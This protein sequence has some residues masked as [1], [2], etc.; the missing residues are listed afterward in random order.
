MFYHIFSLVIH[1]LDLRFI[2]L[3]ENPYLLFSLLM[4]DLAKTHIFPILKTIEENLLQHWTSITMP[5]AVFHENVSLDTVLLFSNL[6][7]NED[8]QESILTRIKM[9]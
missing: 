9:S 3:R 6:L 2:R 7:L 1:H 8:C 4:E 5:G